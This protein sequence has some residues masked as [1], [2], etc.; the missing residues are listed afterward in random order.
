MRQS[1]ARSWRPG[2]MMFF[3]LTQFKKGLADGQK[4]EYTY[5]FVENPQNGSDWKRL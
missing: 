5:H 4:R 2:E 3:P 1:P